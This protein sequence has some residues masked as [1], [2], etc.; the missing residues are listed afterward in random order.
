MSIAHPWT[1]FLIV[2]LIP[3]APL[4]CKGRLALLALPLDLD[5]APTKEQTC[6]PRRYSAEV[7]APYHDMAMLSLVVE[8]A[9]TTPLGSRG[10][11]VLLALLL[12]LDPAPTK[13]QT[14]LPKMRGQHEAWS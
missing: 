3:T 2:E 5:P 13:E 6:L 12:D 9:S 4:G 7:A 1:P 10:R 11:L 8:L 14:C